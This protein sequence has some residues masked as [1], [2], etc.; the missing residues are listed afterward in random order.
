MIQ[1]GWTKRL[2][3]LVGTE[4]NRLDNE[5]GC[6]G[7]WYRSLV[8]KL[9]ADA[10]KRNA[11]NN[12]Q[13]WMGVCSASEIVRDLVTPQEVAAK[14][15]PHQFVHE[16]ARLRHADAQIYSQ[17][18]SILKIGVNTVLPPQ[19]G[20]PEGVRCGVSLPLRTPLFDR[21]GYVDNVRV[22]VR[23]SGAREVRFPYVVKP[24]ALPQ[25]IL[26][27]D[28]TARKVLYK[29]SPASTRHAADLGTET[30]AD[31]HWSSTIDNINSEVVYDAAH[32]QKGRVDLF[33]TGSPTRADVTAYRLSSQMDPAI[34]SGI[35]EGY[36][37]YS[38]GIDDGI[39]GRGAYELAAQA[40][41]SAYQAADDS[42]Q[43]GVRALF[44]AVRSM[45]DQPEPVPIIK[46]AL[47]DLE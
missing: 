43:A 32:F 7:S 21:Q 6:G 46:V 15:E 27:V 9:I 41:T 11:T 30:T 25:P 47:A 44:D 3:E 12:T 38:M 29:E 17:V 31:S 5:F 10:K 42:T 28:F 14:V 35:V 39:V 45:Q 40:A 34:A 16:F 22:V 19:V 36:R 18:E 8:E 33:G 26:E 24:L 1:A 23:N 13:Y 37:R 2:T 4:A 20:A